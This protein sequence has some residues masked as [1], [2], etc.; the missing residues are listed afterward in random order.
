MNKYRK[1]KKLKKCLIDDAK[2]ELMKM[3]MN[4]EMDRRE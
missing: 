1:K 4:K 3:Q 2:E